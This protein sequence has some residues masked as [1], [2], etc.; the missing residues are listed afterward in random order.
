M[1]Y[2]VF[3]TLVVVKSIPCPDAGKA[4]EFGRVN[5]NI[6]CSVNHLKFEQKE[7][8]KYFHT[9]DSAIV[10]LGRVTEE[11]NKSGILNFGDRIEN[12]KLD[13]IK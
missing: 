5:N 4:D 3:W 11:E 6:S 13:S 2:I 10:F 8:S 7:M 12:P 9:K 1:V